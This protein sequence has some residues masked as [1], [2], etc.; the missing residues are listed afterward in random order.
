MKK[1]PYIIIDIITTAIAID[2]LL[3]SAIL[4]LWMQYTFI[5]LL[6]IARIFFYVFNYINDK[7][8]KP[9]KSREEMIKIGIQ[10]IQ[11]TKR[12]IVLFGGDL[13]WTDD[14]IDDLKSIIING[15]YCEI[16]FPKTKLTLQNLQMKKHL[17]DLTNI[18]AKI[19]FT[20]YD[21]GLR[22]IISDYNS[23]NRDDYIL[24]IADRLKIESKAKYLAKKYTFHD[25]ETICNSFL[26]FY[27]ISKTIWHDYT[28]G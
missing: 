24:F 23:D 7:K 16:V 17:Q 3:R 6:V 28:I 22:C 2:A 14:Y 18:G 27:E 21:L 9:M 25:A 8:N 15:K 20:E 4:P 11:N 12:S 10:I 1:L 26:K 5:I 19:Y 13:S